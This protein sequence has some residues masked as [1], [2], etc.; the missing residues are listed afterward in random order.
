MDIQ[1]EKLQLLEWLA[2]LNNPMILKQFIA[3]KKEQEG[4]EDWWDKISADEAGEI[5]D[6]LQ[7]ADRGEV[8][9]HSKVMEQYKKWR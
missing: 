8:V 9:P 5:L 7:Q 1:I 4:E 3:L 6:G 2:K